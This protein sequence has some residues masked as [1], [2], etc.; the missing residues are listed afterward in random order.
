[1]YICFSVV[2]EVKYGQNVIWFHTSHVDKRMGMFI[3]LEKILKEGT[4]CSKND[5]VVF[6]LKAILAGQGHISKVIVLPE[7]CKGRA[8]ILLE[9][10]PL[11]AEL[12]WDVHCSTIIG[13]TEFFSTIL[14]LSNSSNIIFSSILSTD[15]I[16]PFSPCETNSNN[17]PHVLVI[18]SGRCYNILSAALSDLTNVTVLFAKIHLGSVKP[19]FPGLLI[20]P[21]Q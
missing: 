1:M 4:W 8:D 15:Q 3:C 19:G 12:L 2:E 10:I 17:L 7:G 14:K 20:S 6:H 5:L 9:V 21:F 13:K 16:H 11:Q 18:T